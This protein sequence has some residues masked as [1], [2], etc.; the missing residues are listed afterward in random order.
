MAAWWSELSDEELLELRFRDLDLR[1]AGTWIE[2]MIAKLYDELAQRGLRFRPH[3]WLSSEWFSP[4]SVPGIAIPFYLAHPRLMKF[5]RRQ[6]FEVE[7]GTRRSCMRILRHEAGHAIDTAYRLRRKRRWQKTFGLSSQ[8]YPAS[9]R[10]RPYSRDYVL[11]LDW[12]YAQSHPLE[13]FAET[14]AVWLKPRSRWRTEYAGWPALRKLNCVEELVG[15]IADRPWPVRTRVQIDPLRKLKRTLQAHYRAKRRRYGVE[16]A[17]LYDRD[18]RRLFADPPGR[19]G[20]DSAA[21]FL[22]RARSEIRRLVSQWTGQHPYTIDQILNEIVVR[23]RALRL[24]LARSE[25]ETRI[26]AAVM[27]TVQVM[28]Y[29]QSDGHRVAL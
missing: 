23:S 11:H 28:N 22:R 4:D 5:E 21:A 29:L 2:E 12:W 25:R 8:S 9:Y 20:R 14:F 16:L 6:M 24:R 13:D 18:L 3:C 10:P 15:E 27:V 7:G 26:E 17:D 19:R 1:I